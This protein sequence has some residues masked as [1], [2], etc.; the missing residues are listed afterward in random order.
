MV[1]V[2]KKRSTIQNFPWILMCYD[3]TSRKLH[4]LHRECAL[5]IKFFEPAL[6]LMYEKC[7]DNIK[8]CYKAV[9]YFSRLENKTIKNL[10][11]E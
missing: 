11:L 9:L 7:Q 8:L 3:S 1:R 5:T 10:K 4:S 2:P 6:I